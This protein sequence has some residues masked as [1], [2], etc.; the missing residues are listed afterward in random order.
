MRR[1]R[2]NEG[3]KENEGMMDYSW[4]LSLRSGLEDGFVCV[5]VGLAEEKLRNVKRRRKE[6]RERER[7]LGMQMGTGNG[8]GK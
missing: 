6:R 2:K 7:V 4:F 8:K 3:D 1:E 5:C